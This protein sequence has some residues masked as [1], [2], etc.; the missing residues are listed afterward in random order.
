MFIII[1]P[2]WLFDDLKPYPFS[3]S[4]VLFSWDVQ[5]KQNN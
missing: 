2:K 1:H 5:L 3:I 4:L